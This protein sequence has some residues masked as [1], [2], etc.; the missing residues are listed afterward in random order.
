MPQAPKRGK[1]QGKSFDELLKFKGKS[2]Y[3]PTNTDFFRLRRA[4][5]DQTVKTM[6][7]LRF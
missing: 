5:N 3:I 4:Q 1:E 7:E 2:I 6:F